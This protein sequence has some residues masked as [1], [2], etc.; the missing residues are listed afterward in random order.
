MNSSNDIIRR[1][2][3]A[4]A[5]GACAAVGAATVFPDYFNIE[6]PPNIAPLNFDVEGVDGAVA[7]TLRAEDGATLAAN[8]PKVRFPERAWRKFL[9]A[10]AG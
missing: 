10:H 8:G 3:L 4:I 1:S 2:A 6:I 9:S 5:L 7:V